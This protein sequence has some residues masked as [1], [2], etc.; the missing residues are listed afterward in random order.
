MNAMRGFW[1]LWCRDIGSASFIGMAV[2]FVLVFVP[3]ALLLKRPEEAGFMLAFSM[4]GLSTAIAWQRNRLHAAEWA[5]VNPGFVALVRGHARFLLGAAFGVT[6]LAWLLLDV[7]P[8][9]GGLAL[10]LGALFVRLC[11]YRPGSFYLSMIAFFSLILIEPLLGTV[12][13]LNIVSLP[14]ALLVWLWLD[15]RLW[16]SVWQKDAVSI[17]CN[18]MTT[19]GFFLPSWRWLSFTRSVDARLF[20]LSYFGGPAIN[21]ALVLMPVLVLLVSL[22]LKLKG[23]EISFIH[24]WVQFTVMMS[25]MIHWTRAMRWRSTDPLLMLPVFAGWQDFCQHFYRAQLRFLWL[26]GLSITLSSFISVTL[27][28]LPLWI[29]PLAV[30]ATLWGSALSLAFGV[31]CKTSLHTTALM[32][33]MIF[34]LVT[35]DVAVRLS[36]KGSQDP[37]QWLAI[38]GALVPVALLLMYLTRGRLPRN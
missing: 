13:V 25:A 19:G 34:P 4:I 17:Y 36:E 3:I 2:I 21:A 27:F 16:G 30:L 22:L 38:N 5:L 1:P 23:S 28:D 18:G 9:Y 35:V 32:L 31:F 15:R 10:L 11:M 33:L 6:L 29:W 20:P 12:P 37:L 24:L 7:P 14:L 8:G 26:T